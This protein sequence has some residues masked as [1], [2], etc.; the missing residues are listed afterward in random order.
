MNEVPATVCYALVAPGIARITLDRPAKGNAQDTQM[1]YDLNGALMRA[2]HDDS[3]KVIILGASGKH[4]SAG[5]DLKD[6][7]HDSVVR[8]NARMGVYGNIDTSTVAG[9]F[10]WEREVY[11]DSCRRWRSIPKPIIAEVHGAC[12]GGGLQI[13]LGADIRIATPDARLSVMEVRWGLVPDMG[14]TRTLPRL[15]GIDVAKELTYTARVFSG[16]EASRLGVVTRLAVDPLA[17]AAALA[18]EIAARSPDAVRAAKRLFEESWTEPAERT[19]ALEA[20]S[21]LKLIGSPNQMAA[22]TAGLSG[23]APVFADPA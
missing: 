6:H 3:I 14:I 2:A 21:Q 20:A 23:E 11:L 12:F 22:V 13:A 8:A 17:D 16:E 10:A 7:G 1:T 4:F 18:A 19:L 5:H 15:V 9:Y